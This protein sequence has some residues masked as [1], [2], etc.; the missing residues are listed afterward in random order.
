[1]ILYLYLLVQ[2]VLSLVGV[3]A[4]YAMFSILLRSFMDWEM[5]LNGTGGIGIVELVFSMNLFAIL[6]MSTAVD[7]EW[8]QIGLHI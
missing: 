4:Y 5:C 6:V 1:M 8:A 3:G 7:I 2:M